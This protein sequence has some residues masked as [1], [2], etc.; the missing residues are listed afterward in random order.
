MVRFKSLDANLCFKDGTDFVK[1]SLPGGGLAYLR[2]GC[3]CPGLRDVLSK[4]DT[5]FDNASAMLKDSRSSKVA[6]S[7]IPGL[8]TVFVKKHNNKGLRYTLRHLFRKARSFRTWQSAW[9]LEQLSIPTPRPIAAIAFRKNFIL[10]GSYLITEEIEGLIPACDFVL[11]IFANERNFEK[12]L[13]EV[14]NHLSLMHDCGIS[15][16]DL[17]FSNIAARKSSSG[18]IE[19]AGFID[20]DSMKHQSAQITIDGRILELARLAASFIAI[21]SSSG[22][23]PDQAGYCEKLAK[24]YEEAGGAKLEP[25]RVLDT[26]MLWLDKA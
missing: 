21:V 2:A 16:G 23:K 13:S 5:L 7:T 9:M 20:L 15:H 11:A 17:K 12:F 3:D 14:F 22:E 6:L 26:A 10:T 24:L 18:E 19:F 1:K 8:G 4:P 25:S